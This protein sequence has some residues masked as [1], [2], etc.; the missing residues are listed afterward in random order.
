[1]AKPILSKVELLDLI[2]RNR[3]LWLYM[4]I[5][6]GYSYWGATSKLRRLHK[7]G[8][9]VPFIVKDAPRGAWILTEKG[10]ARLRYLHQRGI[11]GKSG[12]WRTREH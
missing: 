8:L 3:I 10:Y 6:K 5:D 7:E 12:Y 4:L 11:Y 1:M 2:A 9:A